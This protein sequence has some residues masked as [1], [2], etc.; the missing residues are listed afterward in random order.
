MTRLDPA[1]TTPTGAFVIS[2]VFDAPR[3]LVWKACSEPEHMGQWFGPKGCV[4]RVVKM[5]FR[6][7]G[8]YHYCL[9]FPGGHEMWGRFMYREIVP[10]EK[11]V[12]IHSFSDENGGLSRHSMSPVWPLEIL[13]T[14]TFTE[15]AG[16][17]TF[18]ITWTP[19]NAT[20][21]E[22]NVFG[23]SHGD[24][25]QGWGGTLDRLADYL[26]HIRA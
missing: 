16:R 5:D 1:S 13:S 3:D 11:V 25:C 10:P 17:T 7:G 9:T 21:E 6:P 4:G 12:Y 15:E 18:T 2:R 8:L 19:Y 20:E 23:A 24:M 22:R 14:L 26:V